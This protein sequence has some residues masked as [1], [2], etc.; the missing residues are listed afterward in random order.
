MD[1]EMVQLKTFF[2]RPEGLEPRLP[3]IQEDEPGVL[4]IE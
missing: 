2:N 4:R 1:I 3:A